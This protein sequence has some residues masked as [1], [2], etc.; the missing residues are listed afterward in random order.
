MRLSAAAMQ[1]GFRHMI[2]SLIKESKMRCSVVLP[3]PG[4]LMVMS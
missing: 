1:L 3:E 2:I 4:E